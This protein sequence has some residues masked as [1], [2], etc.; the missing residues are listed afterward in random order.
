MRR[1]D[2]K[3]PLVGIIVY[4]VDSGGY[5]NLFEARAAA[6]LGAKVQ[7][8]AGHSVRTFERRLRVDGESVYCYINV[9]RERLK[10][11]TEGGDDA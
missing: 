6:R 10:K 9:V 8:A 3:P 4:S 5:T 1:R 7:R 11:M 2:G